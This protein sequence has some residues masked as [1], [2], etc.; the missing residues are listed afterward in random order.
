[1]RLFM[2]GLV[3]HSDAMSLLPL[4]ATNEYV[5]ISIQRG[6]ESPEATIVLSPMDTNHDALLALP[7]IDA[8][9]VIQTAIPVQHS[10]T[11]PLFQSNNRALNTQAR[12]PKI[13]RA[14]AR[15]PVFEKRIVNGIHQW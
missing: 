6:N 10:D 9:A 7:N 2:G 14:A 15:R 5:Q 3:S 4:L 8:K 11:L 12:Q 1:M 13:K